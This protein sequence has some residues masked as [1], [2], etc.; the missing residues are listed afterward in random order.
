[1]LLEAISRRQ[2]TRAESIAREHAFVGLRVLDLALSN[3]NALNRVPGKS[4]IKVAVRGQV[5][6]LESADRSHKEQR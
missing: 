5:S 1:L 2:G 6:Y 4:L 3:A